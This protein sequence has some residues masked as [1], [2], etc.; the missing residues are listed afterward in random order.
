MLAEPIS[1]WQ[2]FQLSV[3]CPNDYIFGRVYLHWSYTGS[4]TVYAHCTL[5]YIQCIHWMALVLARGTQFISYK[6]YL[7]RVYVHQ[8]EGIG[9]LCVGV[10]WTDSGLCFDTGLTVPPGFKLSQTIAAAQ[11][12]RGPELYTQ[13]DFLKPVGLTLGLYL[14]YYMR[15]M[16]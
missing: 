8:W 16:F 13:Q 15:L 1:E 9:H 4:T 2:L 11:L 10:S 7:S 3:L 12:I 6:Y 14:S 5:Q